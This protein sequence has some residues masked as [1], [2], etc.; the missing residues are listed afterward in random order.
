MSC[1]IV[2]VCVCVCV[3]LLDECVLVFLCG[4]L[5]VYFLC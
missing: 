3:C 2:C 4:W 1:L 5:L